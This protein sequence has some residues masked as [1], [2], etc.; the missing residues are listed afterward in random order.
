MNYKG[1][2]IE[3][4]L[5]DKDILKEVKI[6]ETK[7]EP[8]TKE[9]SSPWLKRWTL[10]TVEVPETQIAGIAEK[11]KR[12]ID[13]SHS[14]SWYVDFKNNETHFIIFSDKIFKVDR[15]NKEQYDEAKRY[16]VSLGIPDYQLDFSP[17]IKV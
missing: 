12:A 7:I 11:I 14:G 16:G 6:L 4:S 3:E 5:E 1:V 8:V 2:I 10:H 17:D 9:H 13:S 15:T